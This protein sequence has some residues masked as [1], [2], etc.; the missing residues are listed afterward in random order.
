MRI[1]VATR[2]KD[3]PKN[4]IAR[5]YDAEEAGDDALANI[6]ADMGDDDEVAYRVA[7]NST[8]GAREGAVAYLGKSKDT[9]EGATVG[10][11]VF[12]TAGELERLKPSAVAKGEAKAKGKK[13]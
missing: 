2:S 9:D 4:I 5:V 3:S 12:V 10:P 1:D 6:V 13:R 11:W 7:E 8:V